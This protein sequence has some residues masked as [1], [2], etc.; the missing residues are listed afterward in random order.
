MKKIF[1]SFIVPAY[2]TSRYIGE[3]IDSLESQNYSNYEIIIINDGSID[4]TKKIC[5]EYCK[6]YDNIKLINQN[7][8]GVSY[9]RN[10]GIQEAKGEYIWFIDSDDK[11]K[12][13]VLSD[14]KKHL[15]KN[16]DF[17][18]MGYY[19]MYRTKLKKLVNEDDKISIENIE[20]NLILNNKIGGYI[21]NKIYKKEILIRNKIKF[22]EKKTCCED[23]LFNRMYIKYCKNILI[24]NE[25]YYY[26]RQCKNSATGKLTDKNL[27]S[28]NKVYEEIFDCTE[29]ENV[30]IHIGY[31]YYF[32]AIRLKKN[33]ENKKV[34]NFRRD[35]IKIGKKKKKTA[36]EKSKEFM[37]KYF[38]C[39]F[40]LLKEVKD[41]I[42]MFD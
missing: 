9:S 27:I 12:K 20:E 19:K 36:K 31:D 38:Y 32:N 5:E 10:L 40:V 4:N 42:I 35:I 15:N 25:A 18:V 11:I 34:I 41:R 16:I 8:K 2:N 37:I 33:R 7:N 14:L 28:M 22:D 6:K 24:L 30:R 39:I 1:L 21:A 26:Y 29:N 13:D 23:L 3:C 17:I